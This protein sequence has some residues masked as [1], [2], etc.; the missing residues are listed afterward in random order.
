MYIMLKK[1]YIR[2]PCLIIKQENRKAGNVTTHMEI[3]KNY[4]LLLFH[5]D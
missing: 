2:N 4:N 3:S 5:G 1:K